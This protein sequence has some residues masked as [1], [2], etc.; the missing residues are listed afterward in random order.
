M[1]RAVH[2]RSSHSVEIISDVFF[3]I[4]AVKLSNLIFLKFIIIFLVK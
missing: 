4:M 2:F 3:E 1:R